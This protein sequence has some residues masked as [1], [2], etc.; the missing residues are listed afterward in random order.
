MGVVKAKVPK[1]G[2]KIRSFFG[3]FWRPKIGLIGGPRG[4]NGRVFGRFWVIFWL[5]IGQNRAKSK[6]SPISP[7][8]F[9]H[10]SPIF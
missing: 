4:Q 10:G 2:S 7:V 8:R 9:K 3:E 5:K 1:S 6:R